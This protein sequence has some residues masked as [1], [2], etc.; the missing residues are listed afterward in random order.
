MTTF[1]RLLSNEE[2]SRFAWWLEQ[3]AADGEA[4]ARNMETMGGAGVLE[5]AKKERAEAMA[6]KVLAAR[7]RSTESW[8]AEGASDES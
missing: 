6:A 7:L 5:L 2:R 3:E 1:N 8:G 4:M